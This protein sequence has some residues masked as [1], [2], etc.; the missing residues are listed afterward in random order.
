MKDIR[1]DSELT[2]ENL[3][4]VLKVERS[5]YAGWETGKDTIPLKKLCEFCDYFKLNIDYVTGLSINK[6]SEIK[7]YILNIKYI[8]YNL[9]KF[10]GILNLKQKDLCKLLNIAPSTY[11]AYESN[12]VI[13]Q[14]SFLYTI[15]KTYNYSINN[16]FKEN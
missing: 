2:Q 11:S 13:I 15:S 6:H 1:E 10:R 16:F 7:S 3:S 5:T 8:G 14:T 9:K 4:Q 12:K